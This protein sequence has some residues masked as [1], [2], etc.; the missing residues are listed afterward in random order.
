[1]LT[2]QLDGMSTPLRNSLWNIFHSIYVVGGENIYFPRTTLGQLANRGHVFFF[3]LPAD[4]VPDERYLY[5]RWIKKWFLEADW[6][7]LYDF[8]EWLINFGEASDRYRA[9]ERA[10]LCEELANRVFKE[11][12]SGYRFVDKVL[13]Q[14]TNEEE[15]AAVGSALD[16]SAPFSGVRTHIETAARLLSNRENPDFRNSIKESISAVELVAKNLAGSP[17]ITLGEVLKVLSPDLSLH[18]ALKEGFSRLY[19]WTNDDGGIR[20]AIMDE[21]NLT[22]ADA[23]LM[24]VL[25][26]AFSNYLIDRSIAERQT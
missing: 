6:F 26:S 25:C 16:N 8:F 22:L 21:P 20:H 4:E 15:L 7:L 1:M 14:I 11:E 17:A 9:D 3:K 24:L 5:V 23:R 2:I 18:P 19:G 13:V 10:K 12:N